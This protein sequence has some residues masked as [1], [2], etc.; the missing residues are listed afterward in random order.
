MAKENKKT[1]LEYLKKYW[2]VLVVAIGFIAFITVYC[3]QEYKNAPHYVNTKTIDGEYAIFSVDDDYFM[4]KDLF[5]D[6]VAAQ[7]DTFKSVNFYT[8]LFEE[9]YDTTDVWSSNASNY[10]SDQLQS[11]DQETIFDDLS[12][13]GYYPANIETFKQYYI[14]YFKQM[15]LIQD[16][17]KENSS[18]LDTY[19]ENN[20]SYDYH[21]ILVTVADVTKNEDGTYTANMTDEEST[22]LNQIKEALK[23]KSYMEVKEEFK[24][25]YADLGVYTVSG[26][27]SQFVAPFANAAAE[28]K[29]GEQT[30]EVLS[31]YGYHFIYCQ[32]VDKNEA[33]EDTNFIYNLYNNDQS[34]LTDSILNY[35][36]PKVN[37][38]I[39]DESLK[40]IVE[41]SEVS[42]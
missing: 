7:G 3:V 42:E 30:D 22:L 15:Q 14:T 20:E 25:Y 39:N 37:Y 38:T 11:Y 41:G 29:A 1:A 40:T 8:D 10:V 27:S 21:Y 18:Y 12:D 35:G 2:F 26:L 24:D 28:L 19:F 5:D 9:L 36:L 23:T 4:A 13:M 31:E 17:L 32:N 16:Y 34:I 33:I 6:V